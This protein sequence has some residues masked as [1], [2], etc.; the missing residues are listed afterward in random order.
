MPWIVLGDMNVVRR[1]EE[2]MGGN[3]HWSDVDEDLEKCCAISQL[4]DL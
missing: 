4:D 1:S 2:R 3:L